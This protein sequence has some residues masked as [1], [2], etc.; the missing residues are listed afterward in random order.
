MRASFLVFVGLIFS[1]NLLAGP[2]I[3]DVLVKLSSSAMAEQFEHVL[4]LS[5]GTRNIV[6]DGD[7]IQVNGQ[8]ASDFVLIEC[9]QTKPVE[10][11]C[12]FN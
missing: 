5:A 2:H 3:H 11:Y 4:R 7:T 1:T 9:T 10:I 8:P 6:L 12:L